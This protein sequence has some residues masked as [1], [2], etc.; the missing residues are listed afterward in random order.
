MLGCLSSSPSL[1]RPSSSVLGHS[2]V[3]EPCLCFCVFSCLP[4]LWHLLVPEH[5]LESSCYHSEYP[6]FLTLVGLLLGLGWG[7][8]WALLRRL[9][10]FSMQQT[11]HNPS[12]LRILGC[13]SKLLEDFIG[14]RPAFFGTLVV[15][16]DLVYI[17]N[18]EQYIDIVAI[19]SRS[20][21]LSDANE[22][23]QIVSGIIHITRPE[24]HGAHVLKHRRNPLIALSVD[25][26]SDLVSF[27][28]CLHSFRDCLHITAHVSN[29]NQSIRHLIVVITQC[30]STNAQTFFVAI[31]R[32]FVF[33][34]LTMHISN[35]LKCLRHLDFVVVGFSDS[36]CVP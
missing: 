28:V 29:R 24:L 13:E 11:V 16:L 31:H 25:K 4:V 10:L 20:V 14:L 27:F 22:V 26:T 3:L 34:F 33:L 1:C 7:W 21:L 32:K 6:S 17:P 18:H 19:V 30:A 8:A 2:L 5:I 12:N 15:P 9:A 36:Q 35:I 23:L